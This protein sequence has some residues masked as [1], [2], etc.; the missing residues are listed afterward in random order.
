MVF[1]QKK[2]SNLKVV[3]ICLIIVIVIFTITIAL[4]QYALTVTTY[5]IKTDKTNESFKFVLISDLHNKEFGNN[6]ERLIDKILSQSPEFVIIAGDM[7][8]DTSLDYSVAQTLVQ[9]LSKSVPVYY[10]YGNHEAD[11]EDE[12]NLTKSLETAGA[13]LL[14]NNMVTTPIGADKINI[15]GLKTFPYFE[16]DAPNYDNEERHFFDKFL[17]AQ[18]DNFSL[19][20]CHY[21]ETYTWGFEKFNIDLM[22]CGHTHGGI[23]RLPIFGGVFIPNQELFCDYD[24]GYFDGE[25]AD[26]IITSGLSNS[27]I[28]P[29]INNAPEI[30]VITVN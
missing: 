18:K 25:T 23:I 16:Y 17:E 24:M 10:T 22:L 15:G 11:I 14:N 8:T 28:L 5:N 19:L 26:M 1:T 12:C 30:C 21:P 3:S 20:I 9:N 27:N 4:H 13:T 2:K 29:R 7:V 6:N